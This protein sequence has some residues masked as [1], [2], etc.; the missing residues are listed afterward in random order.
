MIEP[1]R[2]GLDIDGTIAADPVRFAR[3]A[4][5]TVTAKGSVHVVTSRSA[6]GEVETLRELERYGLP[7]TKI[8][9]LP[10]L[11]V[12][13]TLCPHADLDWFLK[14]QWIKVD[15]ALR[16]GLSHFIDDDAKVLGLFGRFASS[17]VP[18]DAH[19]LIAADGD[20][21]ITRCAY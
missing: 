5:Q 19:G 18:V 3:L 6:L 13:Q 14:H 4:R 21:R 2:L 16:N 12:A 11:S 20:F 17:V 8:Y 9:F 15:Y 1:V 10:E 7:Y